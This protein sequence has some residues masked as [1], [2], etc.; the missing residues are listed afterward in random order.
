MSAV[1]QIFRDKMLAAVFTPTLY[2]APPVYLALTRRVAEANTLGSQLDEPPLSANYSRVRYDL[3]SSR[4]R[5]NGFAEY[6][7]TLDINFPEASGNWGT[8]VGWAM[9]DASTGGNVLAS[10]PLGRPNKVVATTVCRVPN[11]GI[12][13]SLFDST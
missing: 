10:G 2:T 13:F 8:V 4:W 6:D 9:V 5:S 7:N 1:S 12:Q 11:G 3:G